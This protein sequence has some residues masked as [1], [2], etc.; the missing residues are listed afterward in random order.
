MGAWMTGSLRV[1]AGWEPLKF[2]NKFEKLGALLA[3]RRWLQTTL[4]S[5]YDGE[6]A[7]G[8]SGWVLT[9]PQSVWGG[10]ASSAALGSDQWVVLLPET[11][12]EGAGP[13]TKSTGQVQP[14]QRGAN[15]THTECWSLR[16]PTPR[17]GLQA[18]KKEIAPQTRPSGQAIINK[19]WHRQNI[20]SRLP[21]GFAWPWLALS[22]EGFPR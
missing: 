14:L 7:A 20:G 16:L 13:V 4:V 10:W 3:D 2:K 8:A 17:V 6:G 18:P 22:P 1:Q 21:A 19:Q 12:P 9:P 11:V 15:K 5:I